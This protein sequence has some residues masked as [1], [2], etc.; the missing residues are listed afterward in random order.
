M[1]QT[2]RLRMFA[3]PN[4]SGKSTIKDVVSTD[5]LGHHLNP[6]DIEWQLRQEPVFDLSKYQ[7]PE[8]A[9]VSNQLTLT[10]KLLTDDKFFSIF[11]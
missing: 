8:L 4:G 3:G 6:D 1:S 11:G 5:Y 10:D 2:K 7:S 9:R